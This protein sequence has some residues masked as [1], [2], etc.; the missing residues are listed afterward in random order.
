MGIIMR[1]NRCGRK[2]VDNNNAF[3]LSCK[4]DG[5]YI[6][7]VLGLIALPAITGIMIL[8]SWLCHK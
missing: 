3:E 7:S 5:D 4:C 8:M 1:C 6:F 2:C